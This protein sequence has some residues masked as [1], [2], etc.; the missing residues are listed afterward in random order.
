DFNEAAGA[1]V[2]PDSLRLIAGEAAVTHRGPVR[3]VLN[4]DLMSP[5]DLR[6]V[7]PVAL[8]ARR[9]D[10]AVHEI[11]IEK[12]IVVQIAELRAEAPASEVDAHGARD[13]LLRRQSRSV[14][15]CDR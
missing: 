1:V 8:T 12:A 13:V 10:V 6:I 5:S 14:A 15:D 2:D 11:Q 9:G 4:H 7:I 3:R